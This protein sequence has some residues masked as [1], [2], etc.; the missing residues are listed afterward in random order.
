MLQP[1]AGELKSMRDWVRWGAS[2]LNEAG[3]FF[4]H[5]TDN[6]L[7][8]ALALILHAVHLNHDLPVEYLDARVTAAEAEAIHALLRE[9]VE[10]RV[11][12]AYLIGEARFAGLDF[13]VDENVLIP[14]SPIAELIAEGFAPWLDA[15]HVGSVLDLCC[16]SGCIGIAC[17]HAFPQALVDLSD[18]SLAALEVA[19]RNIDRHHLEHR[20]R[21]LHADVYDGLDGE[22]YDL[23][24]SNPPYVS[25]AEMATLPDEYRHEPELALEAGE[26]GM[27]VV[28]RILAGG[29]EYLR[30]GGIMVVE[31]GASAELLIA[32]YPEVPFLW[33]DF[34]R[35]G[36]G[37][38]LLTAEQLEDHRDVFE[39]NAT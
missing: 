6:A 2:R 22:Q 23:I 4:G 5:G 11:P 13:Y 9:R 15:D 20:V 7:D 25:R 33:L 16:G 21:A 31:V 32:R 30:P 17:A 29:A 39:D 38:F 12:A 26:D 35:G 37:V 18:I 10:R 28:A 14:R 24:V 19:A 27:D 3:V 8:E 34:E 36:D 1:G